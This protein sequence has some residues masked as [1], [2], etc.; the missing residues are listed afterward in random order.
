[1]FIKAISCGGPYEESSALE[2]VLRP[3]EARATEVH[4]ELLAHARVLDRKIHCTVS[5]GAGAIET[6]LLE[7]GALGGDHR[8]DD[9]GGCA[10]H[11]RLLTSPGRRAATPRRKC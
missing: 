7:F 4:T 3:A 8:D 11:A 6:K 10:R 2:G 9:G 5:G 1:M